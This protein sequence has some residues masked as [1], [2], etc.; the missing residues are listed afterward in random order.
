MKRATA[1]AGAIVAALL[2]Q[3]CVPPKAARPLAPE[4]GVRPSAA[5]GS[6]LIGFKVLSRF[7][8]RGRRFHTGIDLRARRGGGDPVLAARSGKVTR[9]QIMSGYGRLVE[10]RHDDGFH[11]R[12]AHLRRI[13]VRRGQNVRKG[14][15]IGTVGAT[16]RAT[17]EHLH[18]EILTPGH[19]YLD[20]APF[21]PG[22]AN[23]Q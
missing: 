1:V 2:L 21:L 17:T 23:Q 19:R 13:A 20:P 14:D 6:P 5:F 7:G 18:F 9:A 8:P 11:T 3:S 10:I 12:Y 15:R 22:V 4:K 16:G